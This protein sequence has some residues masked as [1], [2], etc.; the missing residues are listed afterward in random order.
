VNY[1]RY[2]VIE[3]IGH[4]SMGVVYRAHDPVIGRTVAIKVVRDLPWL[5]PEQH[6]AFAAR[7]RAEAEAAGPL[8][9]PHIVTI[10]DV[11]D[12][13]L[14]MEFVEGQTL[15]SLLRARQRLPI[16][17]VLEF[18]WKV[19]DALDFAHAKG[20]VHR[21]LKPANIMV[22]P[23]G[24]VK[25]MDFGVARPRARDAGDERHVLGSAAYMAPEQL[26]GQRAE[27]RADIFSLGVVVYELLTGERP[28]AGTSEAAIIEQ[29]KSAPPPP[30][31]KL[32]PALP[33]TYEP[34]LLKALEKDPARR[35]ERAGEFVTALYAA[36]TTVPDL[37][38]VLPTPAAPPEPPPAP[39]PPPSFALLASAFFR[40]TWPAVPPWV[41]PAAVVGAGVV[42]LA[43][44]VWLVTSRSQSR[45]AAAPSPTPGPIAAPTAIPPP[46]GGSLPPVLSSPAP[47]PYPAQRGP[48]AQTVLLVNSDPPGAR[49]FVAGVERGTTPLTLKDP[50]VGPA[51]VRAEKERYL[52]AARLAII[53]PG[54]SVGLSITLAGPGEPPTAVDVL[55]LPDGGILF[56]DG[57]LVGKTNAG[58]QLNPGV[59]VVEVRKESFDPWV[60]EIEV[61]SEAFRVIA[62][63]ERRTT[64]PAP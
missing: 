19:A 10:F 28:F 22:L 60:Q 30:L 45:L 15:A 12:G 23:A 3:E 25:V 9:H 20:V 27:S 1:G 8:H 47:T 11:G 34:I 26:L 7:F 53:T 42:V 2:R 56:I 41:R 32:N 5:T 18:A 57:V 55:S 51:V 24:G 39:E 40:R 48:A 54:Q 13:Y 58:L 17:Q 6:E 16:P 35:Y 33:P 52:P 61:G 44:A 37:V 29:I 4:G 43:L 49:I 64:P 36:T 59:H 62:T 38:V 31:L 14:V 21:E 63:L 50:P 46:G